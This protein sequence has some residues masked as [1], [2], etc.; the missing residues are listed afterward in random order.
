LAQVALKEILKLEDNPYAGHRLKG[1]LREIR[2]LEFSLYGV[3]Y[4]TAYIVLEEEKICLVFM[5]A[6][7]ERFYVKAERRAKTI[8]KDDDIR[9]SK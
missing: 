9:K 3:S 1:S 7:H 4:R 5:V 8:K 2:A 6:P